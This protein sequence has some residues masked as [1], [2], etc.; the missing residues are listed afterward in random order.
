MPAETRML[1]E[2]VRWE[3][4]VSLSDERSGNSPQM[5]YSLGRLELMSP[6]KEH[7]K[8]QEPVR[9]VDHCLL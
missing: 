4:Y 2:N 6:K 7:E 8:D 3:T 1:L 9:C 5:T